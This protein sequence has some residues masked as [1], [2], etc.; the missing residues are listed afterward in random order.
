MEGSHRIPFGYYSQ[1]FR[2]KENSLRELR[3]IGEPVTP[4]EYEDS[5]QD[6][7]F[8]PS[9]SV[10][11]TR[12]PRDYD[13]TTSGMVAHFR[14][15]KGF[16]DV[17]CNLRTTT[18]KGKRYGNEESIRKALEDGELAIVSD[19]ASEP[20]ALPNEASDA[21]FDRAQLHD[22]EGEPVDIPLGRHDGESFRVPSKISS[23]FSLCRNFPQN[24]T[25]YYYFPTSQA[26][27]MLK[28]L[29]APALKANEDY[30]EKPLL[31][32]GKIKNVIRLNYR[33]ILKIECDKFGR[34][35]LFTY[36]EFDKRKHID[37]SAIGRILLFH[38]SL[39]MVQEQPRSMIDNWGQ[40]ALL[41]N[42]YERFLDEVALGNDIKYQEDD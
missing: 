20:P 33:N 1:G 14:H 13:V 2:Y 42:N 27:V 34:I 6:K 22:E 4:E 7:V 9:C 35:N 16:N 40:Y 36:P 19:W 29:L 12:A 24:L 26:P 31:Y 8:C 10:Y 5:M 37:K 18:P 30:L 11:L 28:D 23:V 38:C 3:E 39:D 17:E 15:R 21:E 41:P 32:Y 25:R